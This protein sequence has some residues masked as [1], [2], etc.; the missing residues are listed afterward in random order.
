MGN[1]LCKQRSDRGSTST[2]SPVQRI[3]DRFPKVFMIFVL[4]ETLPNPLISINRCLV[5]TRLTMDN[6]RKMCMSI[7]NI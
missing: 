4:S 1:S 5:T 7:I 2:T 6:G 3:V